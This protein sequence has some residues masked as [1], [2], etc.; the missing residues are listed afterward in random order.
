[1]ARD[2]RAKLRKLARLS[3][4]SQGVIEQICMAGRHSKMPAG[5]SSKVKKF[6]SAMR[7]DLA[8]LN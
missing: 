8:P 4:L 7:R 6:A 2:R 5:Y 1:M 3:E